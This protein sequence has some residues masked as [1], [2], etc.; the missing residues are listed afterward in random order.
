MKRAS[1]FGK[2][3]D[4]AAKIKGAASRG[5]WR[6]S[7]AAWDLEAYAE[8]AYSSSRSSLA[9]INSV[10]DEDNSF[11]LQQP[12]NTRA[13][14]SSISL[15][16]TAVFNT[17]TT[18]D[19]G[20]LS[21]PNK[22]ESIHPRHHHHHSKHRHVASRHRFALYTTTT[23]M[24]LTALITG[25]ALYA[26]IRGQLPDDGWCRAL[27]LAS[28]ALIAMD[29]ALVA[30]ESILFWSAVSQ[31]T[32]PLAQYHAGYK[33]SPGITEQTVAHHS[34]QELDKGSSRS[35]GRYHWKLWLACTVAPWVLSLS[36]L[37]AHGFGW[38]SYW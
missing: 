6:W 1:T 14:F 8:S 26:A 19:A 25:G 20:H 33:S 34:L 22:R 38:D 4:A 29:L 30:F 17:T 24:A 9:T 35:L 16:A 21:Q 11:T 3:I 18:A 7:A 31:L 5:P 13:E 36:L 28:Y 23:D 12:N 10:E 27:G 32:L 37:P 2:A 15:A